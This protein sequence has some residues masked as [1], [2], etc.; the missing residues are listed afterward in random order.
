MNGW[1]AAGLLVA[2]GVSLPIHLHL[3]T[4]AERWLYN[5]RERTATSIRAYQQK[6]LEAAGRSADTAV[7]LAPDDPRVLYDAGTVDL[8]AGHSKKAASR[9]QKSLDALDARPPK[10]AAGE[11][12]R[13]SALYNLGNAH[14]AGGDAAAAV[15][16]YKQALRL[17]PGDTDAKFNLELALR[18]LEK[19]KQQQK[20]SSPKESPQGQRQGERERSDHPGA[21]QPPGQRQPSG[22]PQ[23]DRSAPREKGPQDKPE[24]ERQSPLPQF[25]DQPDMSAQEAASILQAVENLERRERQLQAAQRARQGGK[26]GKD[27]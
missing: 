17:E 9:L 25:R 6:D 18:A 26:G 13:P 8:A 2:A 14:L 15:E 1:L 10:G 19:Q 22:A 5:P 4:W 23:A 12:L 21:D 3:P 24:G 16:A 11:D 20:K 27:W 7:R